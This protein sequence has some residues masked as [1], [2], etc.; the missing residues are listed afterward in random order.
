M[1]ALFYGLALAMIA[2][3]SRAP[4]LVSALGLALTPLVV[5]LGGV[6]NPSTL[7][8]AAATATWTAGLLLV[9][10]HA[11]HPP[12][13]LLAAFAVSGSVLVLVRGLS[14]V[15]M[16]LI[17]LT[18]FAV[19]PKAF[20]RLLHQRLVQLAGALVAVVAAV[21]AVYV[22]V[23]GAL[24]VTSS[25]Q[26]LA[27]HTSTVSAL[28][29]FAKDSPIY[30]RQA[31]GIFGWLDS[32]SPLLVFLLAGLAFL[33][34]FLVALATARPR[35]SLVLLALM[36]LAFVVPAAIVVPHAVRTLS[37]DWQARDGFPLYVGI[38][39]FAGSLAGR[40]RTLR[41]AVVRG[42][43]IAFVSVAVIDQVVDYFW[44]LRRYTVGTFGGLDPFQHVPGG[45]APPVPV[46][47]L[48]GGF[49]L[50]ALAYG[51]WLVH[52]ANATASTSAA[53]S[54]AAPSGAVAA[55]TSPP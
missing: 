49:A 53:E 37:I 19:E 26:Q 2:R 44:A 40:R 20:W 52:L 22:V 11:D 43:T 51:W 9:L 47:V 45:W 10:D 50:V 16:A 14:L 54:R 32:P 18:L 33:A 21:A 17:V 3:W 48:L 5:F 13:G 36:V 55:A 12:P 4:L 38:P 34:L 24:S 35:Q 46:A 31:V 15:W 7:E 42:L 6:V 39:L 29:V 41:P 1:A 8:I 27:P 28:V 23:V 30:A 25:G